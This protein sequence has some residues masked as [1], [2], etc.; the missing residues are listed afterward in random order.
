[1]RH[2]PARHFRAPVAL[3]VLAVGLLLPAAASAQA[4]FPSGPAPAFSKAVSAN[5]GNG[6]IRFLLHGGFDDS[7]HETIVAVSGAGSTSEG[8][9]APAGVALFDRVDTPDGY[10]RTQRATL[11]GETPIA[12]VAAPLGSSFS[13]VVASE[14]GGGRLESIDWHE[15]GAVRDTQLGGDPAGVAV[16]RFLPG[17]SDVVAVSMPG[18]QLA[19]Y[20][21]LRDGFA[22]LDTVSG[23]T[24]GPIATG[25]RPGQP[26]DFLVVSAG[27]SGSR[28]VAIHGPDVPQ[29]VQTLDHSSQPFGASNNR[30]AQDLD[31]FG[32]RWFAWNALGSGGLSA[33]STANGTTGYRPPVLQTDGSFGTPVVLDLFGRGVKDSVAAL[34]GT[35]VNTYDGENGVTGSAPLYGGPAAAALDTDRDHRD[36]LVAAH[37]S[38]VTVFHNDTGTEESF[39]GLSPE[40]LTPSY[41]DVVRGVQVVT[42]RRFDLRLP[43]DSDDRYECVVGEADAWQACS[44]FEPAL[45]VPANGDY[46]VRIRRMMRGTRFWSK[47]QRIAFRV[48]AKVPGGPAVVEHPPAFT[49]YPRFG[50]LAPPSGVRVEYRVDGDGEWIPTDGPTF[51]LPDL[52]EG[53]HSVAL[54]SYDVGAGVASDDPASFDFVVDRT[55]PGAPAKIAGPDGVTAA[56]TATLAFEGEADGTFECLVDQREERGG[57]RVRDP[58][59]PCA[60]PLVLT[61]LGL[62]AHTV[63]VRQTDAAGNHGPSATWTWTVAEKTTEPGV[64]TP[65]PAT[66]TQEHRPAPVVPAPAPA[67]PADDVAPVKPKL[68]VGAPAGKGKAPV[69]TATGRRVAVGCAAPG[70]EGYRCAVTVTRGGKTVGGG[71]RTG[72]GLVPVDLDKATAK[73]VQRLGG[74]KVRVTLAVKTADGETTKTSK[75]V[76]ILPRKVL[77]VP[78]DGLFAFASAT[79]SREA[80]AL[81][82]DVAGQ[83]DGAR[84]ITIVGHTDAVGSADVNRRLGQRR[85]EAFRR[86]LAKHGFDGQVRVASAGDA[87]PRASNATKAGRALN[88][89]VEIDVRY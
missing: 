64:E 3:G 47:E 67:T 82:K 10:G 6:P 71:R 18:D 35:V 74:L 25:P 73:K 58:W 77:V 66:P 49:A 34:D 57:A 79:P 65:A 45:T 14:G 24:T 26:N 29:R 43:V 85:A 78:T 37:G 48:E 52:V 7:G 44:S 23:V 76:R 13:L 86:L 32:A 41:F 88:R 15:G 20:A 70:A 4:T 1:M 55:A 51:A 80:D 38:W 63:A 11:H 61:G 31:A 27:S 56:R 84:T 87:Q 19:F 39:P 2:H 40:A 33:A 42:A 5:S 62:G 89:R 17:M 53:P 21:P 50:V 16:G 46:V 59:E 75:T 30:I 9:P 83:L 60:S 54:R 68:S 22:L 8:Q 36:E 28:I 81:A 12:A 69:A 72:A